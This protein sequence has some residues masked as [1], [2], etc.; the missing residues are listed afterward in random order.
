MAFRTIVF[1]EEDE[2]EEEDPSVYLNTTYDE[3]ARKDACV[4]IQHR[5]LRLQNKA[6]IQVK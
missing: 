1:E 5:E 4:R 3:I 2:E 6:T